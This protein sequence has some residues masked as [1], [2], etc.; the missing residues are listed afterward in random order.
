MKGLKIN[1]SSA[2]FHH[3]VR[4]SETSYS[5]KSVGDNSGRIE[6]LH[7]A[8]G[9]TGAENSC[10]PSSI[11]EAKK[12]ERTAESH[13]LSSGRESQRSVDLMTLSGQSVYLDSDI[14]AELQNKVSST[15]FWEYDTFV[16]ISL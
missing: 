16:F 2:L 1:I 7:R 9:I 12:L 10:L 8:C 15:I 4:L 6:E 13:L 14:S 5:V 11:H 3:A